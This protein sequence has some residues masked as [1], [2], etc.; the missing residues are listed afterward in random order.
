[1]SI[2]HN[3]DFPRIGNH[4]ELIFAEEE[5]WRDEITAHEL[6][7]IGATL[8]KNHWETQRDAGIEWLTVG[9]FAWYDHVL[10]LTT[11]LDIIPSRF[12]SKTA[13]ANDK[14]AQLNLLFALARG[15]HGDGE[16]AIAS[17]MTKWFDTNYHYIVD[18]KSVV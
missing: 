13:Q 12:E 14:T 9:N 4:R 15:Y 2:I 5:Y 7:T 16:K 10:E 8:R 3:L 17:E 11:M 1:M 6:F 18:R